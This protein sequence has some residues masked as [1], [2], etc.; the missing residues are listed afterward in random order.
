[1]GDALVNPWDFV[2]ML[3]GAILFSARTTRRLDPGAANRASA[4]FAVRSHP[5]G[6]GTRGR[7]KTQRGEQWMPI[8]G[9]PTSAAG[10]AA[11]LG[12]A[13]MQLGRQVAHR[14]IDVARA[15]SR[16]G[17]ARGITDFV[18]FGYL[19]RNG[20]S[21]IAVPLG[22]LDVRARPRSR[23][24]DDLA[25]WLDRLQRLTRDDFAPARLVVAEGVLADAVFAVLTR[26][27]TPDRWQAVLLAA[28]AMEEIQASGTAITA[29]PIPGLGPGWLDAADDGSVEWRLACA[30]GS[31]TGAYG[32]QG[33]AD[34]P[35]RHHWL[36]LERGAR[37]F[38]VS[39]K[40]LVRDPRVVAGSR[41]LVAD[42]CAIVLRRLV[43][44][45]QRG[46]RRLALVAASG[47]EANPGDLAALIA[48][49]VD[50]DRVLRLARALMAVRWRRCRGSLVAP[51][52]PTTWPDEA[53]TALRLSCLPWSLGDDQLLAPDEA[54][55][56][57]LTAGD[58]AT[59]VELA[60]RRLT[61]SGLRPPLR[62]AFT[63]AATAR[64]W[65]A[66]LAFPISKRTARALAR[67]F[68]PPN[69]KEIR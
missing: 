37:R 21:N 15:V 13:R 27:D 19:E 59:A 49:A 10:L 35:V 29:G 58:G 52:G 61:A 22:R 11:M 26:T 55:V 32:R 3:E 9:Q 44:G 60:L 66:A 6:H 67:R 47:Y 8:W 39:E 1:M 57:R 18:R 54:M 42:L 5:A 38:R 40:R 17:A 4:P 25:P 53:W 63:D 23:L 2:F 64:L 62:A 14:P 51:P 46:D 30:L 43:E 69:P 56:R 68:E 28:A 45:A 31:A 33:R 36:P 16:L 34:D 65:A 12:E 7:E 50:V 24:V 20:Q 48:G 41:D